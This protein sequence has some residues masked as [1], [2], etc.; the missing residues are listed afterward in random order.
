MPPLYQKLF[1]RGRGSYNSEVISLFL[2]P[3]LRFEALPPRQEV[4]VTVVCR[5][6][7]VKA[8]GCTY[9]C[10]YVHYLMSTCALFERGDFSSLLKIGGLMLHSAEF[11]KCTVRRNNLTAFVNACSEKFADEPDFLKTFLGP[12][13]Q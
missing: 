3:L 9:V 1:I 5:G 13:Q 12:V 6:L 10:I 11:I 7:P 2:S 4:L 8:A